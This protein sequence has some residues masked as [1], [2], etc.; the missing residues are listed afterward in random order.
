LITTRNYSETLSA[1]QE[2]EMKDKKSNRSRRV[3]D[4]IAREISMI[5]L[6]KAANARFMKATVTHAKISSDLKIAHVYV[7]ILTE[8]EKELQLILDTM[9]K[10]AGFFRTEIG[11][12]LK[13]KYTPELRFV[14]D[15]TIEYA[16]RIM[17][18]ID[19]LNL[20]SDEEEETTENNP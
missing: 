19:E 9:N 2:G 5:M 16:Q 7:S 13:L 17:A 12:R 18:Q 8:D 15:E 3:A 1:G 10:A 11:H 4:Q 20:S 14:H 6:T